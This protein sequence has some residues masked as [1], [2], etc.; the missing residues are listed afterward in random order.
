MRSGGH[1]R[2]LGQAATEFA[3]IAPLFLV[4]MLGLIEVGRAVF[5]YNVISNAAREGAREAILAYNQCSNGAAG[6]APCSAPPTGSSVVGVENAIARAGGG[7][8]GF[9]FA[10]ADQ[11]TATGSPVTCTASANRGCVFIFM[12]GGVN[13]ASCRDSVGNPDTGPGPTDHYSLCNYN[14]SKSSGAN[15]VVIEVEYQFEPLVP[16]LK[17]YLGNSLTL[18]AKSEM[19]TEY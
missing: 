13:A 11:A 4:L 1:N 16:L 15:D 6:T 3:L 14:T 12:N 9:N 5:Y 7:T 2:T 8:V 18:W 19:R 17:N 10:N